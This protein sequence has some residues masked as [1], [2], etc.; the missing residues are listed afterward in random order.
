MRVGLVGEDWGTGAGGVGR[1]SERDGQASKQKRTSFVIVLTCSWCVNVPAIG[2]SFAM[3]DC[4]GV[5]V[6]WWLGEFGGR[7]EAD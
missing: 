7:A 2:L 1:W 3:L 5:C 6:V 4:V